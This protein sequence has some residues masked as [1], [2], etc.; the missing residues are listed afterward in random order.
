[1]AKLKQAIGAWERWVDYS[2]I[3]FKIARIPNPRFEEYLAGIKGAQGRKLREG[4]LEFRESSKLNRDVVGRFVILDW[5]DMQDDDD[6]EIPYSK[7]KALEIVH[8]D[9]YYDLYL[10]LQEAARDLDTFRAEQEAESLGN[11]NGSSAGI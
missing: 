11:S 1:M 8:D 4:T 7:E 6:K 3:Q 5:K 2:G 10:F 9:R